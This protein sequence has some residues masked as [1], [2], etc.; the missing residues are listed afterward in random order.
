MRF[1]L[2]EHVGFAIAFGLRSRGIDVTTTVD[3]DLCGAEDE[4][5]VAFA[6]AQNRVVFTND[7]D[8]LRIHAKGMMHPGI[9]YCHQGARSIG[10]IVAALEL[11]DGCLTQ[12]EMR[13]HV[14]FL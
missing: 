2:D 14:E 6:L 8:F 3:A 10:S 7:A 13:G 5:H 11:I 4:E 1:H 12:D 9:V